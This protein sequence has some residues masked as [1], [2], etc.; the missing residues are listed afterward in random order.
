MIFHFQFQMT[1]K[2]FVSDYKIMHGI[3][4]KDETLNWLIQ[5]NLGDYNIYKT[6]FELASNTFVVPVLG[7]RWFDV[8]I[9]PE[10]HER[11]LPDVTTYFVKN[12]LRGKRIIKIGVGCGCDLCIS[13]RV[14]K[15]F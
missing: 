12:F 9:N 5:G 11:L 10:E 8:E 3:D 13:L 4:E 7:E 1:S 15:L 6:I 2:I 14:F